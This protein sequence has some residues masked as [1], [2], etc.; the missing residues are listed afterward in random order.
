MESYPP[1]HI[2]D[3]VSNDVHEWDKK[4]GSY[5]LVNKMFHIS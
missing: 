3:S 2:T 5:K 1:V 4:N